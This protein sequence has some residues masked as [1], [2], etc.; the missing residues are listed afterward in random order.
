MTTYEVKPIGS[1][2]REG[3]TINVIVD[4]AY[5]K[6]LKKLD[7]FSHVMVFWWA[8]EFDN[9]E[10]RSLLE[11]IPPYAPDHTHGIFSTRSPLRPN[12]IMM[13][14]CKIEGI[15]EENGIVTINNIDAFDGTP[16][17]DLKAYYGICD[18]VVG[19]VIPE[20]LSDWPEEYP[21]EGIGLM[22]HEL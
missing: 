11:T 19:S 3:E 22:P 2:K 10:G 5:R 21:E 17:V 15:D 6:A 16:L 14:T 7:K 12:P 4:K 1:I 13:T 9:E 8:T 18:G 20:W